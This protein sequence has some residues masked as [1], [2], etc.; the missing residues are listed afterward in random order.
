MLSHSID[1]QWN[2]T[3]Y[4]RQQLNDELSIDFPLFIHKHCYVPQVV[5]ISF[6]IFVVL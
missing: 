1:L 2:G 4:N 5:F 3:N 6:A